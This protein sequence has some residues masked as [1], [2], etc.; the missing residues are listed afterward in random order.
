MEVGQAIEGNAIEGAGNADGA[1]RGDVVIVDVPWA[2]H[3]EVLTSV[4]AEPAGK[5]VVDCVN[6]LGCD[7]QGACAMTVPDGSAAQQA[8]VPLPESRVTAAFHHLSAP[9]LRNPEIAELGTNVLVLGD[10]RA[11]TYV[12]KAL[13]GRARPARDLRQ[14]A[15][16][17]PRG[18]V[19]RRQPE[20]RRP[21]YRAHAGLRDTAVR[22]PS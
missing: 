16:Q 13:A 19:A 5:L 2:G 20:L 15:A 18:G 21:R 1:R 11:D 3:A 4:R 9:V 14:A 17:R 7:K 12:V 8:A 6:P 10:S 22:P